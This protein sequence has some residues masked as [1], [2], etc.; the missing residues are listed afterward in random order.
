M[1][2]TLK[3]D[4]D[5]WY[6]NSAYKSNSDQFYPVYNQMFIRNNSI[7]QDYNSYYQ[8]TPPSGTWQVNSGQFAISVFSQ[9]DVITDDMNIQVNSEDEKQKIIQIFDENNLFLENVVLQ[10]SGQQLSLTFSDL[11]IGISLDRSGSTRWT[12]SEQQAIQTMK[13]IATKLK[14]TY[15]GN[16]KYLLNIYSGKRYNNL[17]AAYNSLEG[18]VNDKFNRLKTF[19]DD[20]F[21]NV[22]QNV[23]GVR[24]I[25]NTVSPISPTDGDVVYDGLYSNFIIDMNLDQ[26][27]KYYYAIYKYNEDRIFSEPKIVQIYPKENISGLNN[28]NSKIIAGTGQNRSSDLSDFQSLSIWHFQSYGQQN[29]YDFCGK[30]YLGI[31]ASATWIKPENIPVG[32]NAILLQSDSSCVSDDQTDEYEGSE[33]ITV[34]AWVYCFSNLANGSVF[35]RG[36][37]SLVDYDFG[38]NTSSNLYFKKDGASY[39]Y[40]SGSIPNSQWTHISVNFTTSS[41]KFYINGVLDSV[42]AYAS[43]IFSGPANLSI[44]KNINNNSFVGNI[45]QVSVLSGV[46]S[47]Q[48][49]MDIFNLNQKKESD[50]GD[51]QIVLQFFVQPSSDLIGKKLLIVR[52]DEKPVCN[53]FDGNQFLNKIVQI[54]Q[55][56]N[57]VQYDAYSNGSKYDLTN[58]TSA[59]F[60]V[61]VV[62]Q[63]LN[64]QSNIYYV[65]NLNF[66]IPNMQTVKIQYTQQQFSSFSGFELD[67]INGNGKI[68]IVS[69][70]IQN[71]SFNNFIVLR[72]EN[73]YPIAS[74]GQYSGDLVFSGKIINGQIDFVDFNLINEKTYYYSAF[75]VD[76]FFKMSTVKN[77]IGKP[78][79]SADQ[80]EIKP[81]KIECLKYQT[82]SGVVKFQWNNPVLMNMTQLF[83]DDIASLVFKISDQDRNNFNGNGIPSYKISAYGVIDSGIGQ[84]VFDEDMQID[85]FNL[86]QIFNIG[87]QEM[88]NGQSFGTISIP[89]KTLINVDF[90]KYRYIDIKIDVSF[91]FGTFTSNFDSLN[92][93]FYNPIFLSE[94]NINNNFVNKIFYGTSSSD[95]TSI[96]KTQKKYNGQYIGSSGS[97]IHRIYVKNKQDASFSTIRLQTKIYDAAVTETQSD[98]TF[99]PSVQSQIQSNSGII[100]PQILNDQNGKQIGLYYDVTIYPSVK[101]KGVILYYSVSNGSIASVRKINVLFSDIYFQNLKT[102]V[103]VSDGMSSMEQSVKIYSID[104]NYPNTSSKN[105]NIED[106]TVVYWSLTPNSPK[107]PQR[108]IYSQSSGSSGLIS[109]S[110]I[111]GVAKDVFIGPFSNVISPQIIDGQTVFQNHTLTAKYYVNGQQYSVSQKV[112]VLPLVDSGFTSASSFFLMEFDNSKQYLYSDGKNYVKAKIQR[113]ASSS[114]TKFSQPFRDYMSRIGKTIQLLSQGQIIKIVSENDNVEIISGNVIQQIDSQTGQIYLNTDLANIDTQ[115][116]YIE[117]QSGSETYVYFRIK[118][119]KQQKVK[120]VQNSIQAIPQFV[121]YI[122]FKYENQIVIFASTVINNMGNMKMLTA[123]GNIEIGSPPTILVPMPSI[124]ISLV[125]KKVN[126]QLVDSFV[127]NSSQMNELVFFVSSS[128]KNIKNGTKLNYSINNYG[129]KN[130]SVSSIT[131]SQI[132]VESQIDQY[133]QRSYVS[134]FISPISSTDNVNAEINLQI[135]YNGIKTIRCFKI[136]KNNLEN[137]NLYKNNT[138]KFQSGL[139]SQVSSMQISRANHNLINNNEIVYAIGGSN[140]GGILDSVQKYTFGTDS[141]QQC[142]RM[143]YKRMNSM[144]VSYGQYIYT[145]GGLT[146]DAQSLKLQPSN[147]LQRY[148]TVLNSW[149]TLSSSP[150]GIFGGNAFLYGNFIYVLCGS[151]S[152]SYDGNAFIQNDEILKYD[153][154]LNSWEIID[155][156]YQNYKKLHANGIIVS[157]KIHI[158]GGIKNVDGYQTQSAQSF[159][160]DITLNLFSEQNEKYQNIIGNIYSAGNISIGTDLYINAGVLQQKSLTNK[161]YQ[162][163]YSGASYVVSQFIEYPIFVA[164]SGLGSYNDGANDI[165]IS[166]GGFDSGYKTNSLNIII[167][168]YS[169]LKIDKL[170]NVDIDIQVRD[171]NGQLFSGTIQV[172]L[173]SYIQSYVDATDNLNNWEKDNFAF[174]N[175][176]VS[177][178]DGKGKVK[179]RERSDDGIQANSQKI[180]YNGIIYRYKLLIQAQIVD[181]IYIGGVNQ[182]YDIQSSCVNTES[183]SIG[184]VNAYDVNSQKFFII[185]S[186]AKIK[187]FTK[188]NLIQ[189]DIILQSNKMY[190]EMNYEQLIINLQDAKNIQKIGYTDI[191]Q[192]L[193][194]LSGYMS[195]EKYD[196]DNKKLLMFG[197]G[198]FEY[199]K[200]DKSYTSSSVIAI[201]GINKTDSIY[202]LVKIGNQ[203]L[204]GDISEQTESEEVNQLSY[205]IQG[206]SSSTISINGQDQ[207]ILKIIRKNIAKGYAQ[208]IFDISKQIYLKKVQLNSSIPSNTS[209][210][211]KIETGVDGYQFNQDGYESSNNSYDVYRKCRFIKVKIKFYSGLSITNDQI[212]DQ[213]Q[214]SG[215]PVVSGFKLIYKNIVQ[216]IIAIKDEMPA[217]QIILNVNKQNLDI[218]SLVYQNNIQSVDYNVF[219]FKNNNGF[220]YLPKRGISSDGDFWEKTVKVNEFIYKSINGKW[221]NGGNFKVRSISGDIISQNNYSVVPNKGLIVMRNKYNSQIQVSF[222]NNSKT[223][224]II[225]IINKSDE[226]GYVGGIGYSLFNGRLAKKGFDYT[227]DFNLEQ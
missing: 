152:V 1:I 90:S 141:W 85:N 169:D 99:S 46:V 63:T 203:I 42:L 91:Q 138:Y 37:S 113:D 160:Y 52:N 43:S 106:G 161:F 224:F 111:N 82:E 86:N 222:T 5:N 171:F 100:Q 98:L 186:R 68:N 73:G 69:T 205:L 165:I 88:K 74:N 33:G 89:E 61:F 10:D 202:N 189:S 56:T 147:T 198:Q 179:I 170:N 210:S 139:W 92:I 25:R 144:S 143:S 193:V 40:S 134:V 145:F 196:G 80:S 156:S 216:N 140:Q 4:N 55:G 226:V 83:F 153:L 129:Q 22:Y 219:D 117:L 185:P 114:V 39:I 45:S 166:S 97:Y 26:D 217:K 195:E 118:S 135:N 62:D 65:D 199:V 7:I 15:S 201:S 11:L 71:S 223:N 35:S 126:G 190:D 175:N 44:G 131:L 132:K 47:D 81:R 27:Q 9:A 183:A 212:N 103:P 181:P 28:I 12:D 116:S 149:T 128:G 157:D 21:F 115:I 36:T 121:D 109:S 188:V 64:T 130:V 167:N 215:V 208:Y 18:R 162:V 58:G 29:L 54:K 14:Y 194:L 105:K 60:A 50:N 13:R 159:V 214:T 79:V 163:G 34:S 137:E 180:N 192:S 119:Q 142:Q 101:Q 220:M 123:G 96:I 173:T 93:R 120:Y 221:A 146:I 48:D 124:Q 184:N 72:S 107:Y 218:Q 127:Y 57:I 206:Q 23:Y 172:K 67:V 125:G 59:N 227:F 158:S 78:S 31:S 102:S 209:I 3:F 66:K 87:V 8:V 122:D 197:D 174:E 187:S 38:V 148:D 104:R 75:F 112:Q 151:R 168:S 150:M 164:S 200:Y 154:V 6:I 19:K 24:I 30:K 17:C 84:N 213:V 2:N 136:D 211:Y 41:V 133:Q 70:F 53:K 94:K 182:F 176:I 204:L 77:Y 95:N 110:T 207:A 20:I 178:I 32:K 108:A 155:V 191:S 177:V 51:R 225:K 76:R 49:V 16:V